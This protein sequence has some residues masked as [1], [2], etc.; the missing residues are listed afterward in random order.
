M[1]EIL[2]D[3]KYANNIRLLYQNQKG[4]LGTERGNPD[5]TKKC[6]SRLCFI[7]CV[8]FNAYGEYTI[9]YSLQVRPQPARIKGVIVDN[10]RYP[11]D[12][13]VLTENNQLLQT[14][15]NILLDVS[16]NMLSAII[17]QIKALV[18]RKQTPTINF[19]QQLHYRMLTLTHTRQ[20]SKQRPSFF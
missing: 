19:I 4:T 10:T 14:R 18:I 2:R 8:L 11:D 20:R 17:T 13:V 6:S 1:I 5:L 16:N 12:R 15:I 9:R 7:P 3:G